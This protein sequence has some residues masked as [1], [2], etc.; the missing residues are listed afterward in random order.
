M[1]SADGKG[2]SREIRPSVAFAAV[3]LALDVAFSG[4]M[5]FSTLFCPIWF[6]VSLLK[7]AIQRP[8]WGLA[9][10][11]IGIPALT[12][13]IV[14]VNDA[15]Q[16]EV[17]EVNARRIVAAC[18]RYAAENG[19]LPRRLEEL[20]PRYMDSIPVAKY[21]L[22]PMGRFQYFNSGSPMLVWPIVPPYYRKI[23]NFDSRTW[24]YL[25]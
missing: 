9:L 8:G 13:A 18:E 23:Y 3:L 5:L 14:R 12:L 2:S 19:E 16:R 11:R 24:S 25:D 6:L 4:S 20:V 22:S 1:Q 17:A 7:N 10:A 15:V 21:C